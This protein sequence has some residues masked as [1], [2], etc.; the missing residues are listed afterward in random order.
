MNSGSVLYAIDAENGKQ[1]AELHGGWASQ[2]TVLSH[3]G[4]RLFL[5]D[6]GGWVHEYETTDWQ[7]VRAW[8]AQESTARGISISQDDSRLAVSGEDGLVVIW[9]LAADD[10]VMLDRIPV[11]GDR[12]SDIVWIGEDRMGAAALVG[13]L[14]EWQVVELSAG[15]VVDE[16][17]ASLVRGF[18]PEECD[19]Y[20]IEGCPTLEEIRN[21]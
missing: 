2:T 15:A 3:D 11:A 1:L 17:I 8:E 16:A 18:T 5:M 7:P 13:D 12:V 19:T 9:D 21:R 10:P 6:G 20:A 4:S 14:W